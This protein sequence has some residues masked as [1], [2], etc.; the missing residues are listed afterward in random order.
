MRIAYLNF[1][2][3]SG[4]TPN[5]TTTLAALGHDLISVDPTDVLALRDPETRLPRPTPSVALALAASAIRHGRNLFQ[6]R[7][8]TA[9]AFDQHSRRAGELLRSIVPQPDV[10][11]QNGAL[12]APGA[13]PRHRYV[14]LLDNTSLLAQRQATVPH[15][16][17]QAA[18]RFGADWLQRERDTYVHA[19][20]IATFS[21]VAR[22]S[23]I[24]DYGVDPRKIVAV[25]AG[26]NIVP[27][28]DPVRHDDGR[29]LLFVGKEWERKGGPVLLRAFENLR[30]CRPDLRLILAGPPSALVVPAG[31]TNYGVVPLHTVQRL[32]S[33]ATVFVLP[34]CQEPFGIAFLDAMLCKV[35][36]VGTHVGAVPEIVGDTAICV[37]PGDSTALARAIE[38]L[39][40]SPA[41]RLALGEAGR[42][43]V[44]AKGYLWPEVGKR[45]SPLLGQAAFQHLAA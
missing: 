23:L 26:A 4:V 9:Y 21:E 45:L 8:N 33:E 2:S 34:T 19:A 38:R 42:I 25:G 36:C 1:G 22:R 20:A 40:D 11:L 5:I 30:R 18:P 27:T 16:H 13:P 41:L 24:D 31:V 43:R 29:T 39:L 28:T 12:F 15:L 6:Y 3:Q 7:W 35:P 14:L 44:L 10:V 37:P 17:A 32:L